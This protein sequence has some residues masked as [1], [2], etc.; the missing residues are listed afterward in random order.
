[1]ER[2]Y[3]VNGFMDAGK[4]TF[5][6]SLIEEAYFKIDETTLLIVCEDGDVE[7][8]D[9]LMDMLKVEI[10]Y[11]YNQDEFTLEN[12]TKLEKELNPARII[13]EFNGMWSRKDLILPETWTDIMEIAILDAGMFELYARNMK[14]SLSEQVRNAFMVIFNNCNDVEDKIPAFRRNIKAVNPKGNIIFRDKNGEELSIIFE[15]Q[16]P[17]DS[18][19]DIIEIKGDAYSIFYLDSM[20]NPDRYLNKRVKFKARVIKDKGVTKNSFLAGRYAMTCCEL[21]MTLF[22]FICDYAGADELKI[23]EWIEIDGFMNQEHFAD[24]NVTVP[25]CKVNLIR[26]CETPKKEIVDII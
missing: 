22:G 3:F 5:I 13:I 18:N 4:T 2:V 20:E 21:D 11:I 14:S 24:Y 15:D 10:R 26:K 6:Q 23:D 16:L 12:L 9:Y 19:A 1:M 17:Y 25:I 8:D 7:Y